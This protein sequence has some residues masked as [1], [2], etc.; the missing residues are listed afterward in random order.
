M[1]A[2]EQLA[3]ALGAYDQSDQDLQAYRNKIARAESDEEAALTSE[4]F[5]EDEIAKRMGKAQNLKTVYATRLAHKEK[6]QASQVQELEAAYPLAVREL[7]GLI[8]VE[9]DKRQATISAKIISAMD[10]DTDGLTSYEV[11]ALPQVTDALFPFCKPIRVLYGLRPGPYF[12]RPG[13]G[14]SITNAARALLAAHEQ[15][16]L[17]TTSK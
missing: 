7:T 16:K 9:L 4:V 6:I 13:D 3:R 12:G 5:S 1:V 15:F 11:A 17:E 10:V 8:N 14:A 2:F